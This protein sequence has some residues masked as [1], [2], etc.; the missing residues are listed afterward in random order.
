MRQLRPRVSNSNSWKHRPQ[1]LL[2]AFIVAALVALAG[3]SSASALNLPVTTLSEAALASAISTANSTPGPDEIT[4][5]ATGA[6]ELT[7]ALPSIATD[8]TLVGP[9]M[10]KLTIRRSAAAG[11]FSVL[12][13]TDDI[14]P[15]PEVKI[16]G[17]TLTGG[18][19]TQGGGMDVGDYATV[20]LHDVA[21]VNNQA[22]G[23]SGSIW[24]AGIHNAGT[25]KVIGSNISDN[26][27]NITGSAGNALGGGIMNEG[28]LTVDQSTIGRNKAWANGTAAAM[29][30]G[31]MTAY[32]AF[33]AMTR[34]TVAE[35]VV[36]IDA[37]PT[38][39][40]EEGGGIAGNT[41]DAT[42]TSSTIAGNTAFD[43]ANLHLTATI[44]NTIIASPL[45]GGEDCGE[46]TNFSEGFNLSSDS[47]CQ[48]TSD[49]D[50]P[51]TPAD[52]GPLGDNGG[53]LQT[54]A[55][56]PNSAAVDAGTALGFG[57]DGR[58]LARVFDWPAVANKDD[59]S[60]IGAFELQPLPQP[61]SPGGPAQ[62]TGEFTV[63]KVRKG[64]LSVI[65]PAAGR[66]VVRD[67][68][69]RKPLLKRSRVVVN[70]AGTVTVKLKLTSRAKALLKRKT[71]IVV[72]AVVTFTPNG[73][74]AVSK[75]RR[76]K[77]RR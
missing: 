17:L 56:S 29:G 15:T 68:K 24:G 37:D 42:I 23:S 59:G 49:T 14:D 72:E 43:G 51:A 67:S 76:L 47:S 2:A 52:L 3:P 22:L 45:G 74:S 16:Y 5:S 46:T 33:F 34:S 26:T 60:D 9:G 70:A 64:K 77:I 41:A 57:T 1:G 50:L 12:R 35:N 39:V 18:K 10:S 40:Q 20:E 21:V 54:M 32:P 19:A 28:E 69:T 27:A 53:S 44:S 8:V 58:G 65:V 75:K 13:I 55:L 6:I 4:I 30:G 48:F 31:I 62:P 66:L 11:P 71:A 61:P 63:G 7:A 38:L 36:A 73:G 25:L